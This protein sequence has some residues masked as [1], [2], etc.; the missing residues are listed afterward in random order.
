MR[1]YGKLKEAKGSTPFTCF[2]CDVCKKDFGIVI[3]PW[4]VKTGEDEKDFCGMGCY[5]KYVYEGSD[6]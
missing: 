6:E 2:K 1:L 3:H 5:L 4:C